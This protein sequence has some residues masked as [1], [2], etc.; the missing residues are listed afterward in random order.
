M[1][2]RNF[3]AKKLINIVM[4]HIPSTQMLYLSSAIAIELCRNR[5]PDEIA[6]LK[7]LLWH[8]YCSI[9]TILSCP[10]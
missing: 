3:F 10:K 1:P 5:T 8:V 6:E 7:T 2:F 4:K 9:G